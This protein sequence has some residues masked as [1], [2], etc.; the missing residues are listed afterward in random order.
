MTVEWPQ[1]LTSAIGILLRLKVQKLWYTFN[2]YHLNIGSSSQTYLNAD[3]EFRDPRST[4]RKSSN[5]CRFMWAFG[6]CACK[7]CLQM[8]VKLTLLKEWV[9]FKGPRWLFKLCQLV[10]FGEFFRNYFS[11]IFQHRFGTSQGIS[12]LFEVISMSKKT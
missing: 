12:R 11:I 7:S 9:T 1:L 10:F 6:I 5:K 3:F 8:L 2:Y 4:T